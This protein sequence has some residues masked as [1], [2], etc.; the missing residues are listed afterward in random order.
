MLVTVLAPSGPK[1]IGFI[2][3]FMLIASAILLKSVKPFQSSSKTAT[4]QHSEQNRSWPLAV[5]ILLYSLLGTVLYGEHLAVVE[6][7]MLS[8]EE[9]LHFFGQRDLYVGLITLALQ[10]LKQRSKNTASW[11]GLKLTPLITLAIM[12]TVGLYTSLETVLWS[13]VVFRSFN[14][15]Y[16]R[17]AREVY[18]LTKLNR[19]KIL[20]DT[21]LY[22]AGD[23][24]GIWL[25]Q[26]LMYH[27][28]DYLQVGL[29]MIPLIIA[30]MIINQKI[31]KTLNA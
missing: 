29:M 17:P 3:A 11:L 1:L 24:I 7:A 22:R 28:F 12:L 4:H 6:I 10:L 19:F 21:V 23:L 26:L 20:I 14:Y 2:A 16:L 9:Q 18:H 8:P 15:S 5:L 25:F 27:Q 13:M 31:V 30:W